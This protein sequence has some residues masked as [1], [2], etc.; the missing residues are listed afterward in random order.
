MVASQLGIPW[1]VK[2]DTLI[3]LSALEALKKLSRLLRYSS[4]NFFL[5]EPHIFWKN[6]FK[7]VPIKCIFGCTLLLNLQGCSFFFL[8]TTRLNVNLLTDFLIR[9]EI[10]QMR[11]YSA[12]L[13]AHGTKVKNYSYLRLEVFSISHSILLKIYEFS[14]LK[15]HL[16]TK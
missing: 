1:P 10:T 5:R 15:R 4:L 6:I 3:L 2:A 13:C 7:I 9:I 8:T 16:V 12:F 11:P 14:H